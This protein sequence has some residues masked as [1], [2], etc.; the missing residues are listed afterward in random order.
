MAGLRKDHT[1]SARGGEPYHIPYG[2]LFPGFALDAVR[3]RALH[4]KT[5]LLPTLTGRTV[6]P[7]TILGGQCH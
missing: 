3:F 1:S 4:V 5:P 7:G 2:D 6:H